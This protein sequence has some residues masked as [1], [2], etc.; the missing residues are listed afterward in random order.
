MRYVSGP[1]VEIQAAGERWADVA[2][3]EATPPLAR[4]ADGSQLSGNILL[5]PHEDLPDTFN[6][7]L[8][9]TLDWSEVDFK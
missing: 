9:R 3:F 7:A 6:R 8:V 2:F 5:R 4:L 1:R